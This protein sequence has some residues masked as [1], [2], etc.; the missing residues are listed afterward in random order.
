MRTKS[1][2]LDVLQPSSSLSVLEDNLQEMFMCYFKIGNGI[3][4]GIRG[5]YL[6]DFGFFGVSKFTE[7]WLVELP[8]HANE[9]ST[10][11]K[12][13]FGSK[14]DWL[15]MAWVDLQLKIFVKTFEVGVMLKISIYT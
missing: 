12:H 1:C 10:S 14:P 2:C 6:V 13:S 11:P 5:A 9:S 3:S 8:V 15:D 4:I 7:G